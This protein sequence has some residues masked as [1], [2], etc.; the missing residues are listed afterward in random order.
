MN[1]NRRARIQALINKLEDIKEDIDF[2]KD[3]EQEYYDNMPESI[4]AGERGDK[5]QEAI[6]NLE[7]TLDYLNDVT[8]FLEEALA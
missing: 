3:E 5:A 1:N 4:Q 6:D 8:G 7:S 2:I